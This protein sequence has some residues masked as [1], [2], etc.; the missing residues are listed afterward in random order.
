M[1]D[2]TC[3]FLA[4]NFSEDFATWLIGEPITLTEL[5][6]S[7]L[8]NEPIHA[9]ALILRQ[10][11]KL[12]LHIE[13]Q[14]NPDPNMPFRMADY[15][16]RVYRRFPEKQMLQY[17]IYLKKTDSELVSID[18]FNI[19]G[20]QHR[21]KVLRL[22]E[23]QTETFK[24]APGLL[25][26]ATLSNTTE[27]ATALIEVGN[28]IDRIEDRQTKS[29]ITASTA[30]LAGLVLNKDLIQTVLRT[31][32]MKESV[33][34]QEIKQE[35]RQEGVVE[36]RSQGRQEGVAEG[37][38]Q[39]IEEATRLIAVNLIR[40]GF[41]LENIVKYTGLSVEQVQQLQQEISNL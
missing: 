14:T 2:N 18:T 31:E 34:Y 7:E 41:S 10:S 16:L 33:I 17:V 35:G 37:R 23:E 1:F 5:S 28:I 20:L 27:P 29:N 4:E 19:G 15:R 13:F 3:K 6:P 22:W 12:I 9:D 11:E 24:R 8:S 40:D 36:G 32:V 30:I 38:F 25:P 21:F 26:F 39:G